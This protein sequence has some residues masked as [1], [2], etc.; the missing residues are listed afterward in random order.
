MS[1]MP[2]RNDPCPC[3]SGQ[4]YKKCCGLVGAT[5]PAV[6]LEAPATVAPAPSSP[7][8]AAPALTSAVL[9][10]LV[11]M[12]NA[13]RLVESERRARELATQYPASGLVWK[14]LGVVLSMQRK[15]ALSAL[16]RAAQLLP[17]DAETHSN[18]GIALLEVR[19]VDAAIACF[20]R[21][22][23]IKP[24]YAE[25]H[26]QLGNAL[27]DLGRL[28]EAAT[29]YRR[30]LQINPAYPD[31]HNNLGNA[32]LHLGRFEDAAASYQRALAI[33]PEYAEVHNNLGNA[34]QELGRLEEAVASHQRALE[35]KPDFAEAQSNLVGALL[36][37]GRFE[38]AVASYR[39]AVAIRPEYAKVHNN[40]GNALLHL[41][42]SQEAAASCRRAISLQSDFAE[43][44]STL[45][46]ALLDL[47]RLEEAVASYRAAL[48]IKPDFAEAHNNLGNAL[49]GLARFEEAMASYGR[50][51]DLRPDYVE[52]HSN[53]GAALR[54]QGRAAEAEA[55]CRRALAI[56]PNSLAA[57]ATLAET[58]VDQGHFAAAEVLFQRAISIERD[59][60]EAWVGIARLRKMSMADSVWLGEAQR[61]AQLPLR[62]REAI[63][64]Q[65]ALGK[66]FDDVR[67]F[68]QAFLHYQRANELTRLGGV[69]HD[70]AR[71]TKTIDQLIHFYDGQWLEQMRPH[72]LRSQRP[73]F[74]VGMPRSGT[75][76]TEQ[77]LA[78]H[79]AVF[80]AGELMYWSNA[81]AKY[82][83]SAGEAAIIGGVLAKLSG[84]Y[85]RLLG[86]LS[87][88][89]QRV[90]DKMPS[91]F[92]FLGLIHAA[93]PE[94][95][96]IHMR[97]DPIDTCLSIYFQDFG[98]VLSYVNDLG[99]LAH[100][101]REYWRLMHHWQTVLPKGAMLDV[102]YE[103]LIE[104][105]EGWSRKLVEFI[106]LPWDPRCLDFHE[107][108]RSVV[109][110]SKWQVRQKI[111]KT[112]VARWRN[113]EQHIAALLPLL[114][115]DPGV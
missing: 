47:G 6:L 4:K 2:G 41:G 10:Q 39:S 5:A 77:I 58:Q 107:T 110:L 99:D 74:I 19:R 45:G 12:L 63:S 13:G 35:F 83:S 69:R 91:N 92:M 38:E 95:R 55:S 25:V 20:R 115:W 51:L 62:P 111:S 18:L 94:A 53:L 93:L 54:L 109:T 36:R 46:N 48:A 70:R 37:L 27:L 98:A 56:D 78:S 67:D 66:Y 80:G 82:Q 29:S 113:Y 14:I 7:P 31:G 72:G 22:L 79:P 50:A 102:P 86:G 75:S 32:L 76:L 114:Q 34:W 96:I 73:V 33:K 89:A 112:S 23:A 108:R 90:I 8:R 40:L 3:G 17:Q 21:A 42:R 61:V 97:R 60:P 71:L 84:D 30:A 88:D 104:D 81:S 44:H 100:Y 101:Y 9:S 106:G 26:N 105:Q 68:D 24:D 64:L 59:F 49:R 28:E 65:Y 103:A 57:I 15:P 43:A 85:L 87:V 16:E 11:A 52:A 1:D